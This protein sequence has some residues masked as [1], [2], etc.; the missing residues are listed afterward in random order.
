[1]SGSSSSIVMGRKGRK[2]GSSLFSCIELFFFAIWLLFTGITGYY[3]GYDPNATPEP[4]PVVSPSSTSS[5][6]I[7]VQPPTQAKVP[8]EIVPPPC[9]KAG[10]KIRRD[11]YQTDFPEGGYTFDE[12]RSLWKCSQSSGNTSESLHLPNVDL[13][14]TKWQS[15]LTVPPKN[16]FEKYLS[17]YPADTRAT[18]PVVIFSHK[19]LRSFEEVSDV[20]KVLDVAVV[21]DRAGVCVAVTETFH[22]V[23]SYHMLHAE[24]QKDGSFALSA[25]FVDGRVLP[26]EEHYAATRRMLLEYFRHNEAVQDVVEKDVPKYGGGKVTVGVLVE[27]EDDLELFLNSFASARKKG[28]SP[29][30]FAVFTTSETV[31]RDL[32][33]TKIKVVHLPFLKNLGQG[34]VDGRYR[35]HFIQAWLAFACANALVKMMWQSPAT[36]WFERPDNIVKSFPVVETSWSFKGRQDKRSAPFFISFDFFIAQGVERPVHLLHELILHFD[37][38]LAWQSLDAVASYRLTENNSRYGTT[39]HILPPTKVLHTALLASDPSKV[40][41]A[42]DSS[43]PPFVIVVPKDF[44]NPEKPKEVLKA[45]GL[46]YL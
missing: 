3:F 38:I 39:T 25:N 14:K 12:L 1:M 20:C 19:P 21:P 8:N 35:R 46:W 34:V 18:Q 33:E 22:D 37:L 17:Q 5:N 11:I 13:K 32:V 10:M 16:F 45:A 36:I 26:T 43:E 41:D 40:R 24:R 2:K 4:C 31:L 15:I 29:N 30:K 6:S 7:A 9:V 44:D 23:A 42:V 27:D 28:I